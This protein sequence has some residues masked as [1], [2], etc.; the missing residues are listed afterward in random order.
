[1][2]K[3]ILVRHGQS[4]GNVKNILS[5]DPDK[6]PL[7]A[8]GVEQALHAAEEL[9][10]TGIVPALFSSNILRAHQT[11]K[12]I[13]SRFGVEPIIDERLAERYMGEFNNKPISPV[14]GWHRK[15]LT[16]GDLHG[17]ESWNDITK[18][19]REFIESNKNK[20]LIV[21]VS[22][23]DTIK[24]FMSETLQCDEFPVLGIR[25]HN[26]SFTVIDTVKKHVLL[27][28]SLSLPKEVFE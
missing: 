10:A 11:A 19:V 17:F 4:E 3:I 5:H 2:S 14:P 24:A 27:V 1:M 26:A 28:S 9:A 22:H 12:I 25:V 6:F 16:S 15:L 18:R 7:T 21:A 23:G 8:K 13:G 20:D